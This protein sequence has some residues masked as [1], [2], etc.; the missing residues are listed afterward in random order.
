MWSQGEPCDGSAGK[1]LVLP[2]RLLRASPG[3]RGERGRFT[4]KGGG[5]RRKHGGGDGPFAV[6]RSTEKEVTGKCIV[7]RVGSRSSSCSS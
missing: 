2:A 3:C 6:A 1:G 7:Q 5:R 4:L